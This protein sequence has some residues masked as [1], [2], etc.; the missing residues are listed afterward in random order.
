MKM[1]K[2]SKKFTLLEK[3]VLLEEQ[4]KELTQELELIKKQEQGYMLTNDTIQLSRAGTMGASKIIPL[5]YP[6]R[7]LTFKG[8]ESKV[9]DGLVTKNPTKETAIVV[10]SAP[11][12]L[13]RV[14]KDAIKVIADE[15]LNN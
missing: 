11:S 2:L 3:L 6:Y 14:L 1:D 5:P 8:I 10:V 13:T 7:M 9:E 12:N 4:K 15:Y